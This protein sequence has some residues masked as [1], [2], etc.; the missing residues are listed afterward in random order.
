MLNA[1]PF[2]ITIHSCKL[3]NA[4]LTFYLTHHLQQ[5]RPHHRHVDSLQ[6]YHLVL[7][8]LPWLDLAK[9]W[10]IQLADIAAVHTVLRTIIVP[11]TPLVV[12]SWEYLVTVTVHP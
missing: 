11:S 1:I 7:G 4:N 3:S 2:P 5:L 10:A 12:Q 8:F 6:Q 9:S